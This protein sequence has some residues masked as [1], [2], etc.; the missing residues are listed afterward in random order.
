MF[1]PCMND[2]SKLEDQQHKNY[3]LQTMFVYEVV[4]KHWNIIIII[5]T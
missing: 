3:D 2:Y 5:I 1:M 4:D